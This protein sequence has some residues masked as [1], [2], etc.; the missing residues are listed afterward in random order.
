MNEVSNSHQPNELLFLYI[1]YCNIMV[2]LTIYLM[3]IYYYQIQ[4]ERNHLSLIFFWACILSIE[5]ITNIIHN[6]RFLSYL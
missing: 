4:M 1:L 2:L 3:Y 5:N 6:Q